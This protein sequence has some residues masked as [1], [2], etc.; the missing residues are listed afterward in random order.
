[1]ATS[2]KIAG[3]APVDSLTNLMRRAREGD[4]SAV[5]ALRQ[6]LSADIGILE[7]AGDMARQV[8]ATLVNNAA[9]SNLYF[10]EGLDTKMNR[11]RTDLAGA[12]PSPL[13][14]LLADRIALCWLSLHDAEARFTQQ[15]K[16]LNIKQVECWQRRIDS[17]HKRYLSAIKALAT[18]RKLA[19]P[20]LQVNIARKQ[21]NVMNAASE[22]A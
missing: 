11:L 5:P 8:Q 7:A 21:V 16:D 12:D 3:N 17:A 10:K 9:G 18:I 1:V 4:E 6:V 15:S 13:E 19:L 14:R 2:N 20:A 22:G